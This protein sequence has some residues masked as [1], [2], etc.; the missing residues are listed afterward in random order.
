MSEAQVLQKV[1]MKASKLGARL[2]RNQ[3]GTYE[4]KDGTI[5]SSGMG[6]GSSDLIGWTPTVITPEM[7]GTTVALFTAIECKAPKLKPTHKGKQPTP[8]QQNFINTINRIGGIAGVCW[9]ENDL[10]P[11]LRRQHG[12]NGS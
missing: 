4:L 6:K 7:V 9:S 10:E 2:F 8:E 5:I 3:V 12:Q 11:I 1:R